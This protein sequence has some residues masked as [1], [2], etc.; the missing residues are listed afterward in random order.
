[1]AE[2]S[3]IGGPHP[4]TVVFGEATDQQSHLQCCQLAAA[5]FGAPLSEQ[6]YLKREAYLGQ[7][8]LTRHG[9]WRTWCIRL[10][11]AGPPV[12]QVVA[13]C[14]TI[15][16]SLL[17]WGEGGEGGD[18]GVVGEKK[19]YCIA[20]VVTHPDFRGR[21]LAS[22]LL[23]RLGRWLDGPG[24]AAASMLYTSI[25]NCSKFYHDRG[26]RM[27]PAYEAVLSFPTPGVHLPS[28]QAS[29]PT[30]RLLGRTEISELCVRDV[31]SIR[32]SFRGLQGNEDERHVSVLPTPEIMAW[33]QDRGDFTASKVSREKTTTP[34]LHHGSI[35]E[36]TDTWLYWYHDYRKQH[37]AIQRIHLGVSSNSQTQ[38]VDALA[39][40]LLDAANDAGKRNLPRV[41]IWDPDAATLEAANTLGTAHGV[42]VDYGERVGSSMPSIRWREADLSRKTIVHNNEKFAYS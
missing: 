22:A 24:G 8:P 16:R 2:T 15:Q 28:D 18:G 1:M 10:T 41:V 32:T 26:W 35:C 23:E 17:V 36:S 5:A 34:P 25:E 33:M 38:L 31:E 21:G 42:K 37:L 27:L 7:Q 40:L 3:T 14:T 19:G 4:L 13:A 29:F 12:G 9:G 6:D 11:N 30:T 39:A 20:S